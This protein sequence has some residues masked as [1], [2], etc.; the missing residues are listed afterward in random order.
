MSEAGSDRDLIALVANEQ[1]SFRTILMAGLAALVVL[2]CTSAA[3]GL[4]YFQ[5]SQRLTHSAAVLQQQATNLERQAF[6]ARRDLDAQN[7][8]MAGQDVRIR[9]I[10]EEMRH[11]RDAGGVVQGTEEGAL[12]A[13]RVYLQYG[14]ISPDD[15]RLV[16]QFSQDAV[17]A[18]GAAPVAPTPAKALLKGVAALIAWNRDGND[19]RAEDGVLPE[20]LSTAQANFA[21]AFADPATS[22]MAHAGDAWIRFLFASSGLSNY[23][24][25]DCQ[26]VFTAITA[27]QVDGSPGAQ[28]L[29]WQAQCERKIGQ[30]AEALRDYARSLDLSMSAGNPQ[31]F[32]FAQRTLAMNA[33]HG[34]GTTLIAAQSMPDDDRNVRTAV[35][36]AR[37]ACPVAAD[38]TGSPRMKLAVAC[39]RVA[40][41]LRA[42]LRQTPNQISGTGEN[43]SFAYLRDSDFQRAFANAQSVERTGLFPWTELVRALGARHVPNAP[44]AAAVR[45]EADR[46]ISFFEVGA[47]NLCELHRLLSDQLYGEAVRIIREQHPHETVDCPTT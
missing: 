46:N 39:L 47:F 4:Y 27:S 1:R 37:R 42:S 30:T 19:I 7:N 16:E 6:K 15:E 13:A 11:G 33:Y 9:I 21:R 17:L 5:V 44:N 41:N 23:K 45:E 3:L 12:A 22:H 18:A 34:V 32:D 40:M 31:S 24:Q 10:D 2:V 25:A 35:T 26:A 38:A 29:Y 36:I 28:P 43:L 20:A 8:R 14:R